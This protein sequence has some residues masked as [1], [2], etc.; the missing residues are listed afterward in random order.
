M[1]MRADDFTKSVRAAREAFL[2][3]GRAHDRVRSEI[4]ASWRR[5]SVSGVKPE[6]RQLPDV[7]MVDLHGRLYVA[8]QP[9]LEDLA[10]RLHDTSTSVMLADRNARVITRLVSDQGLRRRLDRANSVDGASL[11]EEVAGTNGLGSVLAEG[12]PVEVKGP[13]HYIEGF[14]G[15][16]CVGAPVRSPLSGQ[17]EGVVTLAVRYEDSNDLLLPLALKVAE[18]IRQRMLLQ[19]TA[20]ERMLLDTFLSVARRS[21]RPVISVTNQLVITNPAAARLL[22]GVDHALL[23]DIAADQSASG[24]TR[25]ADLPL[26]G[27]E[28]VSARVRPVDDGA[29]VFGAIIEIER[30]AERASPAAKTARAE[31][32]GLVGRSSAWAE[33]CVTARGLVRA[34]LPIVAYGERGVG[35]VA[36]LQAALDA[37]R[38]PSA[39]VDAALEPVLGLAKWMASVQAILAQQRTV[40][41]RH[42][43]LL[44][45]GAAA[46]VAAVGQEGPTS[47]RVMATVTTEEPTIPEGH[48]ELVDRLAA[49]PLRVPPLRQRQED[50]IP[51][52]ETIGRQHA[53]GSEQPRWSTEALHALAL[54]AW[55]GNVRE[56]LTT[57]RRAIADAGRGEIR[58]V[59]LPP[60]LHRRPHYVRRSNLEQAEI[61]AIRSALAAH[62]G[63][64]QQAARALGISRSTLYRKLEAFALDL[65]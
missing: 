56:L 45:P 44:S 54:A 51:L 53:V 43:E 42:A 38:Q 32:P 21:N 48:C 50:I 18:E 25:R 5:S 52:A 4:E 26:A 37:A 62:A 35:K 15:F 41:V 63:N 27:G 34:G 28:V 57:V 31:L 40:I 46:A 14:H 23:W 65:A 9:V 33:V 12:G 3:T 1:G 10:E 2:S 20:R 17:I 6:L 16:S 59:H 39:V 36:T 64:K 60:S 19:A 61:D 55:P 58:P 11:H 49:A 24:G 30:P 13:E 7:D 22:D 29:I 8:A 47:A